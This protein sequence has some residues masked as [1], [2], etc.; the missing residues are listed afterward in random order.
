MSKNLNP[1]A[2]SY[3]ICDI[4]SKVFVSFLSKSN[5]KASLPQHCILY[6]YVMKRCYCRKQSFK[7]NAQLEMKKT[8][9]DA[10]DIAHMAHLF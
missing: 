4:K 9:T 7:V 3:I 6:S 1:L 10:N 8:E 5:K 2:I